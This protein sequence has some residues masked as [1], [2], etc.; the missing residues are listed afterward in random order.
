MNKIQKCVQDLVI[1]H[2]SADTKTIC[3]NMGIIILSL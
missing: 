3:E 2:G 1:E